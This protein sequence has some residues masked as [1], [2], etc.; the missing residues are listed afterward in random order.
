MEIGIVVLFEFI[1]LNK[2]LLNPVSITDGLG[3]V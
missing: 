3:R 1:T 2:I